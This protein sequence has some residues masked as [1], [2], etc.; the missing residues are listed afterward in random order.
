MLVSKFISFVVLF[1]LFLPFCFGDYF[2]NTLINLT[3][4][5][6]S[7][8]VVEQWNFSGLHDYSSGFFVTNL[9]FVGHHGFVLYPLSFNF[10]GENVSYVG[11]S[12]P[13]YSVFTNSSVT[14]FSNISVVLNVSTAFFVN[15]C[16]LNLSYSSAS[17]TFN[18]SYVPSCVDNS[19]RISC[20]LVE[21]G[22][23][24]FVVNATEVVSVTVVTEEE[25]DE[26]KA[27]I[28]SYVL[29]KLE[30]QRLA[31]YRN[32]T[33]R[34]FLERLLSSE[35]DVDGFCDDGELPFKDPDCDFTLD[36]LLCRGD[37]CIFNYMWTAK[38]MLMLSFFVFVFHRKTAGSLGFI[39]LIFLVLVIFYVPQ[40]RAGVGDLIDGIKGAESLTPDILEHS[41]YDFA[42]FS[43][44]Q[45]E[46]ISVMRDQSFQRRILSTTKAVNGL[47]DDGEFPVKDP[48]CGVT[49]DT[50][51]CRNGDCIFYY[52]W[53]CKVILIFCTFLFIT[54]RTPKKTAWV[55]LALLFLLVLFYVPQVNHLF[56]DYL[57]QFWERV[58]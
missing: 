47:C 36:T 40:I 7:V 58:V 14:I 13:Y 37:S 24:T 54:S 12:F 44:E 27:A 15:N 56:Y 52:M 4:C 33:S 53:F 50:V 30:E 8:S 25:E 41:S 26:S 46:L 42:G 38:V 43:A 11:S 29:Q 48:D 57:Q 20:L 45:V 39:T 10:S 23:N 31:E 34:N 3:G 18:D 19:V 55:I 51:L 49:M 22:N 16:S 9:T 32:K 21:Y 5:N 6:S 2:N 17:G 35:S 28:V 1:L